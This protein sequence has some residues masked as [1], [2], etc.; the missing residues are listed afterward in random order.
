MT[1]ASKAKVTIRE[2]A[3][4]QGDNPAID[5]KSAVVTDS[6]GRTIKLRK[7]SPLMRYDL[8]KL[9]GAEHINNAGVMGNAVLAFSITEID[10][11]PVFPPATEAELRHIIQRLDEEGMA[12][13][14]KAYADN[15]WTDGPID[16]AALKN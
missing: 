14:D 3:A 6:I 8:Y 1:D 7:I 12:A 15:G 16:K 13:A 11:A 5:K 2:P 9:V 10:G 4:H